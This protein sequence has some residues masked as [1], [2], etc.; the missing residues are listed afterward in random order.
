MAEQKKYEY[1]LGRRK[2]STAIVKLYQQ[3]SWNVTLETKNWKK[4]TLEEF[5]GWNRYLLEDAL[6]SFSVLGEDMKDRFDVE[7]KVY[8]GGLK[9]QAEAISLWLARALVNF[10]NEYRPQ[11]K[12]YGLLKRNSKE[13]ERK[14]YGLRKARK[15]PQWTKR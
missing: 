2:K 7:I 6:Y 3:G 5:F 11:L 15:S 14:K 10:N 13:K 1:W 4:K 12:P 9:G 8:W